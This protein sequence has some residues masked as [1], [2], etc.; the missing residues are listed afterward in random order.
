EADPVA[1]REHRRGTYRVRH[2]QEHRGG[3]DGGGQDAGDFRVVDARLLISDPLHKYVDVEVDVDVDVIVGVD[4]IVDVDLDGDHVNV[5]V[6]VNVNDN[7][8]PIES[9]SPSQLH[10]SPQH[11]RHPAKQLYARRPLLPQRDRD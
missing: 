2:Q 9:D 11:A 3:G 5:N 4:V 7:D 6:N 1:Q 8:S 10:Q